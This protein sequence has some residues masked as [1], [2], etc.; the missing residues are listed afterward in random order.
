VKQRSA[1]F[2]DATLAWNTIADFPVAASG[3]PLAPVL[4]DAAFSTGSLK[5]VAADWTASR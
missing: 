1:T 2:L 3:S 4:I 5:D